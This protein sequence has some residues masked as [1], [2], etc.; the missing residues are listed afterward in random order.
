MMSRVVSVLLMLASSSAALADEE[1]PRELKKDWPNTDFTTFSIP[2]N[3]FISGGPS[4]DGIPSIN[5]PLFRDLNKQDWSS[6]EPVISIKVGSEA[7]AYPVSILI[8]H[9]IVNDVIDGLPVAVTFCPLC[10]SG[11]VFVRRVGGKATL[12]GTTGMLRNSDMVMYDHL[13][14][15]WWQQFLGEAVLGSSTGAE[16]K[17]VPARTE[18]LGKFS[19]RHPDGKV[20]VP[21]SPGERPYGRNPY[22]RYDTGKRPFLYD[23]TYRGPVPALARVVVVGKQ[24]W[25][26]SLVRKSGPIEE[27]N[28][29]IR[30]EEGQLSP[31]DAPVIAAGREIGNV[32]VERRVD[33]A[34]VDEIHDIPFAFAFLA[35]VPDGVIHHLE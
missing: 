34:W 28:L 30:Y 11:I 31:L 23:G 4:K 32:I 19:A 14:Q 22:P 6:R 12:F 3:E 5:R 7:R 33:G 27:G 8:W 15:S 25:S 1:I 35:F 13:T 9:E 18:A 10:N 2:L 16:L 29:R 17:R 24:A 21:N 20:L 26:L